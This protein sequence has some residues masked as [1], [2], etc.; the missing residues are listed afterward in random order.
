MTMALR[1]CADVAELIPQ[2]SVRSWT[3]A[4]L[5]MLWG[6]RALAESPPYFSANQYGAPSRSDGWLGLEPTQV[7]RE[8]FQSGGRISY[9]YSPLSIRLGAPSETPTRSHVVSDLLLVEAGMAARVVGGLDVGLV[10][11]WHAFQAGQGLSGIGSGP[12]LAATALG[13]TRLTLGYSLEFEEWGLRPFLTGHVPTGDSANFAGEGAFHGELGVV[14]GRS[15]PEFEVALDVRAHLRESRTLGLVRLS[16]Q[17][18]ISL[19][20]RFR[21]NSLSWLGLEAYVAP[22][23]ESQPAPEGGSPALVLPSEVL[24]TASFELDRWLIGLGLGVGL[25]LSHTSSITGEQG[26]FLA[27]TTPNLRTLLDARYQF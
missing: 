13:D 20:G 10:L 8:D 26:G 23:L 5:V 22:S 12:P 9:L 11:P 1:V 27:P 6:G 15:T 2:R 18:R 7:M 21:L 14:L 16:N 4:S 17:L 24:A 25:P 19:G 3:F